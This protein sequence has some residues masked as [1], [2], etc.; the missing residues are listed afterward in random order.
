[1]VARDS[2]SQA[3]AALSDPSRR[4]MV[5]RLCE[6]DA[7]LVELAEPLDMS[8]QAVSKHLRV[9]E[10]AGLVTRTQ[11]AQRRPAHLEAEVFDLM[12]KWIDRYRRQAEDRYRRLDAVLATMP[13]PT[14]PPPKTGAQP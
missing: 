12:T 7:A 14:P 5:A 2:L 4:A 1:M 3:F 11:D 13:D 10:D 6:S 9:L 8:M